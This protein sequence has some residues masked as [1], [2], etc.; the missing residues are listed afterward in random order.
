MESNESRHE[1]RCVPKVQVMC[2]LFNERPEI[3]KVDLLQHWH[4][5]RLLRRT[6]QGCEQ[7][8]SNGVEALNVGAVF[9]DRQEG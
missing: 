2:F 5:E 3:G 7:H 8:H 1:Q 4:D 9:V 6:L